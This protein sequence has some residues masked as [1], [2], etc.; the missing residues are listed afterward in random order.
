MKE[1]VNLDVPKSPWHLSRAIQRFYRFYNYER[2]PEGLGNV[3]PADSY[4][5]RAEGIL[6]RWKALKARTREES[7][8]R[9]RTSRRQQHT[10]NP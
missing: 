7:A 1:E 5:G 3:T 9:Y 2:H 6:A 4:F 10:K 8:K